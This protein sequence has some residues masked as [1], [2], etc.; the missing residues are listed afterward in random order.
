MN[1]FITIKSKGKINIGDAV[2]IDK[3]GYARKIRRFRAARPPVLRED[4]FD[5]LDKEYAV[6]CRINPPIK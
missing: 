2:Y 4:R 1:E 6:R 5:T 3:K